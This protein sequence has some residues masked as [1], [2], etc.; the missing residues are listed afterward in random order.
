MAYERRPLWNPQVCGTSQTSCFS[1]ALTSKLA[2]PDV[3]VSPKSPS[4]TVSNSLKPDVGVQKINLSSIF[5]HD[6]MQEN[7][8]R[9][10]LIKLL[11][12]PHSSMHRDRITFQA[13]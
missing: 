4:T 12:M 8:L 11:C 9:G 6:S 1:S 3:E 13:G 10:T 2:S 7:A 5:Q